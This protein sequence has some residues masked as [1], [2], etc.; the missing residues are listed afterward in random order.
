M[1]IPTV[2]RSLLTATGPS[3]YETA[4]AAAFRDAASQFAEVTTDVMG[5]VWARVKGAS[6]GPRLAIVGH[7]DEIGLI[8]THIDDN[9]FLRFIGVGGWDPQILVGQRVEISTRN[10]AIRG[11][12]GKKP[13]HLLKDDERKKAPEIKDLHIDIGAKDADEARGMVRIGDVAV[14]SGEP[15]E[16]P[17]ERAVSRSMDNRLGCYVAYEAARLVAE[18]GGAPGEVV[19]VAAVQEETTFGGSRTTAYSLRPDLA[20]VVD[21]THATDAPGVETGELGVHAFGSGPVIERGS[22]INPRIFELLYDTAEAESIPFTVQASARHTGTDLDAMHLSR[23]GIPCGGIG[24]PLRY[25]HSAVEMV[26]LDDIANAAKLIAA[27]AR[28]LS[29]DASFER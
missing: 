2:L 12:V 29:A 6:D 17:N 18:A 22:N 4:P 11:V 3:G 16:L 19:A 20:I 25:M 5:S 13:I 27:F 9:G 15:V 26:Q 14:I 1:P 10:G 28:R 24:L 21:V 23:G 8:V 7:I